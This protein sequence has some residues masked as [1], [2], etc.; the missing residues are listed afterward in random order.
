M[1]ESQKNTIWIICSERSSLVFITAVVC[2]K[3][4]R[5][6]IKALFVVS[7]PTVV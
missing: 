3:V 5:Q 2:K 4:L 7:T 1:N 6:A